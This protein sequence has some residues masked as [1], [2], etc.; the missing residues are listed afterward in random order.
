MLIVTVMTPRVVSS[1]TTTTKRPADL[2]QIE[3]KKQQL[4]NPIAVMLTHF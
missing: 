4:R 2:K 1:T 3:Q